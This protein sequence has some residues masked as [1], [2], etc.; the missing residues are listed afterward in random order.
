MAEDAAGGGHGRKYLYEDEETDQQNRNENGKQISK[1]TT[2]Q[3]NQYKIK[4]DTG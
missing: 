4:P 1:A 2:V 3:Q